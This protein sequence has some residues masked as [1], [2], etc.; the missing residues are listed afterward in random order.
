MR[1]EDIVAQRI[2]RALAKDYALLSYHLP[3]NSE[4]GYLEVDGEKIETPYWSF[5]HITDIVKKEFE[6]RY[7][8]QDIYPIGF[9][10]E[11]Y[12]SEDK[13]LEIYATGGAGLIQYTIRSRKA[14]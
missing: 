2:R 11:V 9:R 5:T 14:V 12:V 10:G 8:V 1:A 7:K 3:Y 4:V 6:R 13:E